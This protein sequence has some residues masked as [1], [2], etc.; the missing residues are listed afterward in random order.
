M[1]DRDISE[2]EQLL[3]KKLLTLQHQDIK[4]PYLSSKLMSTVP[5]PLIIPDKF[6]RSHKSVCVLNHNYVQ[7]TDDANHV[8]GISQE[9]NHF[10][11]NDDESF[12]GS[13]VEDGFDCNRDI[14]KSGNSYQSLIGIFKEMTSHI[15][16]TPEARML[17]QKAKTMMT[18]I[19]MD[20]LKI[21]KDKS[22][23]NTF[24]VGNVVATRMSN[25]KKQK[26]FHSKNY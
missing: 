19:S 25:C 8:P 14:S 6:Q 1:R 5:T 20:A 9:S 16:D 12:K 3:K 21:N 15:D 2:P 22:S 10:G 4:G 24:V 17:I 7:D 11:S 26:V 13:I 23:N 18:Q